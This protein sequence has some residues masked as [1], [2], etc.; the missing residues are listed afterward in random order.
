MPWKKRGSKSYYYHSQRIN[1][2]VINK[3]LGRAHAAQTDA[4]RAA[5]L[6]DERARERAESEKYDYMFE[7]YDNVQSHINL[8][9]DVH[10]VLA[11]YHKHKGQWRKKRIFKNK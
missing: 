5:A 1:G 4:Q 7:Q 3:Y 8:L 6:S 10:M 11:G 9:V 2:H